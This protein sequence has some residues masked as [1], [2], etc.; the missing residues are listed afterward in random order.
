MQDDIEVGG[1][2]GEIGRVEVAEDGFYASGFP[3]L[4]SPGFIADQSSEIVI[5]VF[6][7]N[8]IVKDLATNVAGNALIRTISGILP[9][10][11]ILT[12]L[13]VEGIV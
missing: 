4:L 3:K 6:E 5:G 9:V 10:T 12:V 1:N 2:L 13:S 8:E 11:R 7:L